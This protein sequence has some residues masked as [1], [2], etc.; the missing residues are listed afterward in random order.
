M[1]TATNGHNDHGDITQE[2]VLVLNQNYEPLNVCTLK[3]AVVLVF[4]EKAEVLDAYGDVLRS[5]SGIYDAP[6]VIRLFRM[7]RRPRPRVKL[8]RKEVFMRDNYICQYCGKRGGD[9]TIDHIIPRSR[10]GEHTWENVV[11]ACRSCNHRKGGKTLQ[12]A[13]MRLLTE[14]VEPSAGIYYAIDRRITNGQL[15]HWLPFLPGIE[16]QASNDP[17]SSSSG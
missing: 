3:R 5:A 8:S 7:I 4:S 16:T 11:T 9:L 6:S 13:H 14:P 17:L 2:P 12:Q 10:G 1:T 15:D